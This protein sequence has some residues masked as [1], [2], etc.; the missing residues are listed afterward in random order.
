MAAKASRQRPA[1][2]KAAL[3]DPF[4][5]AWPPLDETLGEELV[6]ELRGALGAAGLGRAKGRHGDA[7]GRK[8]R[9]KRG[10]GASERRKA[11]DEKMEGEGLKGGDEKMEVGGRAE[12]AMMGNREASV[13][14]D[15]T[16]MKEKAVDEERVNRT[17]EE[18]GKTDNTQAARM[19]KAKSVDD[20][21]EEVHAKVA[22]ETSGDAGLS[23]GPR[24]GGWSDASVRREAALGVN[25]VIRGLERDELSLVLVCGTARP[26][27]LPRLLAALC[28]SR[29]VPAAQLGA[30]SAA[31]A[32]LL[33]LRSVLALGV[34]RDAP[35][36][37]KAAERIARRL[38][39]L[40]APWLSGEA[41]GVGTAACV[42]VGVGACRLLP[43]N[44]KRLVSNPARRKRKRS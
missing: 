10:D 22:D 4:H 35:R 19:D 16:E 11:T 31:V 25:E 26:P 17:G 8:R 36:L 32:P 21:N 29:A 41:P 7:A 15:S 3:G 38:P 40:R 37:A 20:A 39:P 24:R 44:V 30:L 1:R 28:A 2:V 18:G 23:A 12:S 9:A 14:D 27:L 13:D 5:L 43:S 34:R 6:E 42:D 33:G